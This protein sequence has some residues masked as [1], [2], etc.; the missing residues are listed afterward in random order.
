MVGSARNY[1]YDPD[2]I[3]FLREATMIAWQGFLTEM[4]KGRKPEDRL[5]YPGLRIKMEKAGIW[6]P[7]SNASSAPTYAGTAGTP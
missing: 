7:T 5:A 2:D 1:N 4:K 3:G 6:P